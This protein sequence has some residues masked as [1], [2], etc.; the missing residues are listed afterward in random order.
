M[1]QSY[2]DNFYNTFQPPLEPSSFAKFIEP[3]LKPNQKIL[4]VGCGNGRD[5]YYF[6]Q[7][8][9]NISGFDLINVK[10]FLGS[11]FIQGDVGESIP[12]SD[13]YYCRFFIH[14]LQEKI[15]DKFL[16][17]IKTTSPNCTL[18]LETRSTRGITND[19]KTETNFKS[20]IGKEHFRMLYSMKYL[21]NKLEQNFNVFYIHESNNFSVYKS[22]SPYLIRIMATPK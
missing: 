3:Y 8:D 22:E 1:N 18:Y 20:P 14:T 17:N 2:W 12:P 9:Y 11:S 5:T 7:Q 19:T 13:V 10:K 15:L 21:Y 4:D 6:E 16:N